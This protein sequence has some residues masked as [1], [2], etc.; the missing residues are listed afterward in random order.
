M[1]LQLSEPRPALIL[2]RELAVAED[3]APEAGE[4]LR[5]GALDSVPEEGTRRSDDSHP[6]TWNPGAGWSFL[7]SRV[8]AKRGNQARQVGQAVQPREDARDAHR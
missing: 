5:L 7:E 8:V 3:L 6:T 2:P 4:A 1:P